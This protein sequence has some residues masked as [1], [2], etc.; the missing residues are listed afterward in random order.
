MLLSRGYDKNRFVAS[1]F[2]V[3]EEMAD[4]VFVPG[5]GTEVPFN[6]DNLG[7]DIM[8]YQTPHPDVVRDY[9]DGRWIR[10]LSETAK[11]VLPDQSPNYV[12]LRH[13]PAAHRTAVLNHLGV[14]PEQSAVLDKWGFHGTNDVILSLDLGL[15]S[16][17]IRDG[18]L[19][20]LISGG[21]GF[22]CAAALIRWG[23]S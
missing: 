6:P 10:A 15:K 3:D 20:V 11:K 17:A 16:G 18:S 7:S 23:A 19:V 1:A 13:L 2:T 12:A 22:T 5:G 4:E 9:L 8:F 14:G 21:I